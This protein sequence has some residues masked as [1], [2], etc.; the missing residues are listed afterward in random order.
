VRRCKECGKDKPLEKFYP[1]RHVCKPCLI[2]LQRKARRNETANEI[3][4]WL[5]KWGR[6]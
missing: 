2:Y 4:Y 5:Q 6:A 3:S 1:H